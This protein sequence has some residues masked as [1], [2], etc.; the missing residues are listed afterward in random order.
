MLV[1]VNDQS[2]AELAR[3]GSLEPASDAADVAR[4]LFAANLGSIAEALAATPAA[5]AS[6]ATVTVDRSPATVRITATVP[7]R[8]PVFGVLFFRPVTDVAVQANGGAR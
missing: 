2:D 3:T 6:A 7:V 4:D 5:I 1:A 8:T